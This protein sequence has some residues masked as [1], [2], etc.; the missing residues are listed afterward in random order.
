MSEI[1]IYKN[2]TSELSQLDKMHKTNRVFSRLLMPAHEVRQCDFFAAE[3]K[4]VEVPR[5]YVSLLR[6]IPCGRMLV[7]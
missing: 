3:L 4:E 1:I 7:K 5:E 2:G 6:W